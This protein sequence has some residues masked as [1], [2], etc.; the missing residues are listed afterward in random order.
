MDARVESAHYLA[1]EDNERRLKDRIAMVF[2]DDPRHLTYHAVMSSEQ[3]LPKGSDAI[4]HIEHVAKGTGAQCII[5]DTVQSI[6]NPSATNKNYDQTVEEYDALRKLAHRLGLAIIVVHHC[7]KSSDVASAPLEKVI[8][9]IGITGTAET[10]LVM[11]QLTGSKDCKLH[12]TGKDVEQ[13]EK[14]LSWTGSGF[15][16]GD[17]VREAQLGST[18]KLVLELIRESPRC[19]QKYL[20]DTIGKDQGQVA[21][22]IDRL[23]EVGLVI[24]KEKT[25][26]AL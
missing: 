26:M 15:E 7:K 24:K 17:D 9:S 18:Q 20:V 19:T 22:A 2:K 3:P 14:Y 23:V 25:L 8:G 21:R 5:V 10:I 6:L 11:E 12:V 16:I 1:A 13:C 4:L